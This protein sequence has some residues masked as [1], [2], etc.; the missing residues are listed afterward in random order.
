MHARK[1]GRQNF[2]EGIPWKTLTYKTQKEMDG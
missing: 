1:A 2:G